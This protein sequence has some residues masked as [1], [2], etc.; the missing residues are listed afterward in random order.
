MAS[1]W[2][3]KVIVLFMVTPRHLKV[4]LHS[5]G[6]SSITTVTSLQVLSFFGLPIKT[7]LDLETFKVRRFVLNHEGSLDRSLL[8]KISI[9]VTQELLK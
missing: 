7:N 1:T 5:S 8:I 3:P 4:S 9:S 2:S 6:A